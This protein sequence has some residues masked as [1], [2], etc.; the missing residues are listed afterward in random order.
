MS[1]FRC[2]IGIENYVWLVCLDLILAAGSK[3]ATDEAVDHLN[4]TEQHLQTAGCQQNT[5]QYDVEDH[6][7]LRFCAVWPWL[8][9]SQVG[10]TACTV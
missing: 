7:I 1:G 9:V 8:T 3:Q 2:H 6:D 5:E 4:G 10:F